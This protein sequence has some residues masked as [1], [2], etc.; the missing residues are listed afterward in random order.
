MAEVVFLEDAVLLSVDDVLPLFST[1]RV[2]HAV[3]EGQSARRSSTEFSHSQHSILT[4]TAYLSAH[5]HIKLDPTAVLTPSKLIQPFKP[6]S[7]YTT[8]SSNPVPVPTSLLGPAPS[9][10][11]CSLLCSCATLSAE[12]GALGPSPS[13]LRRTL[14]VRPRLFPPT[15]VGTSSRVDD[16]LN[17]LAFFTVDWYDERLADRSTLGMGLLR[18]SPF[19]RSGETVRSFVADISVPNDQGGLMMK[20]MRMVTMI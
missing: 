8:F 19:C 12:A 20:G 1:H 18:K 3:Y 11:S 16:S 15:R 14:S 13:V 5:A 10:L 17:N 6:G 9:L 4:I 2:G 7:T